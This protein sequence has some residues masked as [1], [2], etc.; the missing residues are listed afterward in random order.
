VVSAA[1]DGDTAG[2][3]EALALLRTIAASLTVGRPK[4]PG[5]PPALM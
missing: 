2:L 1:A 3:D 4:E 5:R